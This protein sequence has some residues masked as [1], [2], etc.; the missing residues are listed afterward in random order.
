MSEQPLICR[1]ARF[2][3]ID[4][5]VTG[6][7]AELPGQLADLRDRLRRDGLAE[8]TEP[9][10]RVDGNASSKG[11]VAVA[12]HLLGLAGFAETDILVPIEFEGRRQIVDLGKVE[13]LRTHTGFLVGGV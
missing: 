5:A 2:G 9:A 4:L 8:T 13:I 11:R 1:D 6:L 3:A 7:A 12:E 10:A